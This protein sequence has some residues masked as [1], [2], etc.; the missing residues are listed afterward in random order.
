MKYILV[1]TH[2][3]DSLEV[4]AA[5]FKPEYQ[6]DETATYE[7]CLEEFKSKRYEYVFIDVDLLQPLQKEN[8]YKPVLQSFWRVFPSA[9]IIVLSTQ[10]L[11]RDAVKA[12]KAGAS[13]YLTYP[14]DIRE[15]KLVVD[16]IDENVRLQSELDY[17]REKSWRG[18]S[19][20]VL[21][22][23]SSLMKEVFDKVRSVAQT[24]STVL[25]TGETGTGKGVIANLLHQHSR[26]RENQLISVHCGAIPDTLLESELFGHEKGSFTGAV[27]RKLGKFEIAD[28]GTIFVDEIGTISSA[29]QIKLLH[30]L[31]N[32]TF[33]RVGGE[34]S[35][36][37][38]VRIIA[39][40]NANL[41][42]MCH[43]GA[44]R[45]DLYYRLNVFPVEI[46]PLR[47]R[48]DD[49][50]ALLE[51]F[52]KKLNRFGAKEI[53]KSPAFTSE[54]VILLKLDYSHCNYQR[55]QDKSVL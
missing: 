41:K 26:R 4:I 40:T 2:N 28:G 34:V 27:R 21:R 15:V 46:P 5:C 36:A 52:L 45:Q 54:K 18:E 23:S 10:E 9:E 48:I 31:Q 6:V 39:A 30:V 50:P 24:E 13:D 8:G 1:A 20:A 51:Q 17:L 22:T 44:F 33:H 37:A 55:R 19:L 38:D 11:I 43:E 16:T 3:R 53:R 12:V 42:A 47:E 35:I 29:M 7:S 25:L 32:K 49:I 14:L